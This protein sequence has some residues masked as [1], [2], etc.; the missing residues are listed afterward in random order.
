MNKHPSFY[1]KY[2]HLSTIRCFI[3]VLITPVA[4]RSTTITIT[5]INIKLKESQQ[6]AFESIKKQQQ[7][8]KWKYRFIQELFIQTQI[9]NK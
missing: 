1:S 7:S 2:L 3:K 9:I 4:V 8:K 6:N 5:K